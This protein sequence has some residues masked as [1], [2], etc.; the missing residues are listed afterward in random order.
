LPPEAQ[1]SSDPLGSIVFVRKFGAY[2]AARITRRVIDVTLKAYSFFHLNLAYSAISEE[3]RP[4]VVEK[5]YWP[6]LRLAKQHNL[7]FGVEASA[8]TLETINAI[9]PE[10]IN[11]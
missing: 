11:E 6:L 7:P 10:W 4:E 5:C 2:K 3:R 8:W 1:K 9:D